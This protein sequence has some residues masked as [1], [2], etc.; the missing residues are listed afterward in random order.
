[1]WSVARDHARAKALLDE[2]DGLMCGMRGGP[3]MLEPLGGMSVRA[4]SLHYRH[5]PPANP[6]ASFPSYRLGAP[7]SAFRP[8]GDD[9]ARVANSA[10]RGALPAVQRSLL[11]YVRS[12][13]RPEPVVLGADTSSL[14]LFSFIFFLFFTFSKNIHFFLCAIHTHYHD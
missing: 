10:P 2:L 9:Y 13:S 11:N 6:A 4:P 14:F 1:M 3:I 5:E 12:R 8:K 7:L